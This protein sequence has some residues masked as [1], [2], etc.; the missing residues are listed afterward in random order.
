VPD[1]D[2]LYGRCE[3]EMSPV[4]MSESGSDTFTGDILLEYYSLN[5]DARKHATQTSALSS[6][7]SLSQI[8]LHAVPECLL[9]AIY[10]MFSFISILC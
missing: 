7:I 10:T 1:P 6:L 9:T 8:F 3:S 4:N 2:Q 5:H